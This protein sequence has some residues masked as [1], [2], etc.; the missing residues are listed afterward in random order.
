MEIR[1]YANVA[2]PILAKLLRARIVSAR[3]AAGSSL[4]AT[5]GTL[6]AKRATAGSLLPL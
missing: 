1:P 3:W 4:A 6:G 5:G 2:I